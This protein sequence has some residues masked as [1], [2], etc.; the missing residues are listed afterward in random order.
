MARPPAS[1]LKAAGRHGR[2]CLHSQFTSVMHLFFK[3][4]QN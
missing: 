4:K 1:S 3:I 2:R